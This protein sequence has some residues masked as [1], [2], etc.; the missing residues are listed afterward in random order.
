MKELPTRQELA[1]YFAIHGGYAYPDEMLK[2]IEDV[3]R[4][5]FGMTVVILRGV[6]R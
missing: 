1:H 3:Y 5:D 2:L 4:R 6:P